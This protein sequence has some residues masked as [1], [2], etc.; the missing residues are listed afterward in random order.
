MF[1][2]INMGDV[3][4][5]LIDMAVWYERAV[6]AADNHCIDQDDM[7]IPYHDDATDEEN[8]IYWAGAAAELRRMAEMYNPYR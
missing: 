8:R 6:W 2:K 5:S 1:M 7:P 3:Y 4:Q